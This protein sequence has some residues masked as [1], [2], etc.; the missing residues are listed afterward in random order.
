MWTLWLVRNQNVFESKKTN[1]KELE[2][3]IVVRTNSLCEAI[4]LIEPSNLSIW[5][6]N[7]YGLVL[8]CSKRA[9]NVVSIGSASIVGFIDAS[10]KKTDGDNL[11]AGIGGHM[12]DFAALHLYAG[13]LGFE[14]QRLNE[15]YA[16]LYALRKA[17]FLN[18]NLIELEFDHQGAYWEWRH[19]PIDGAIPQHLYVIRQLNT[20]RADRNSLIE[21]NLVNEDC[22]AL[23]IYLENLFGR[24]EEIWYNDM[25]LGLVGSQ[26]QSI[27]E[28]DLNA[29]IENAEAEILEEDEMAG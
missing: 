10:W 25:G 18:Y 12:H 4:R 19:S 15:Y 1:K 20:R 21:L 26:F 14:E 2:R 13:C 17:F 27:R 3:L 5:I 16:M 29:V 23:A 22:N 8:S 24:V 6:R 9:K 11:K 28:G 7:S